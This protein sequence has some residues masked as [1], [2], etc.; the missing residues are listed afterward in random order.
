MP[1]HA[2]F[3]HSQ[4]VYFS[5]SHSANPRYSRCMSMQPHI[6]HAQRLPAPFARGLDLLLTRL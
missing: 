2:D 6:T 1:K 5:A 4:I 3:Q